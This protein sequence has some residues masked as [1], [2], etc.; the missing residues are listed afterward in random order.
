VSWQQLQQQGQVVAG[1]GLEL[2]L[3]QELLLLQQMV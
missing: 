2:L 3:Q 1:R